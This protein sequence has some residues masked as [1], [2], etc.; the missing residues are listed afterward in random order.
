MSIS[1]LMNDLLC[2]A[3]ITAESTAR[4]TEEIPALVK[5]EAGLADTMLKSQNTN[6][7]IILFLQSSEPD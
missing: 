4:D 7:S 2:N 3:I 5:R 6:S 1:S